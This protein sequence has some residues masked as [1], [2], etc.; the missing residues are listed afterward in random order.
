MSQWNPRP[1]VIKSRFDGS[2]PQ[3]SQQIAV[4]ELAI[5]GE[6]QPL[7]FRVTTYIDDKEHNFL[8]FEE[9]ML[10]CDLNNLWVNTIGWNDPYCGISAFFVY[11]HTVTLD[12]GQTV[13]A[14]PITSLFDVHQDAQ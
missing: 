5:D 9:A 10:F 1:F 12:N 6:W 4:V 8:T 14:Q 11:G 7:Y 13:E 2:F 3:P